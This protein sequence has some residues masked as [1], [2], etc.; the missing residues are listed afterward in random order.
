MP[1]IY[2]KIKEEMMMKGMSE[3]EAQTRAAKI[4]NAAHPNTPVGRY[5]DSKMKKKKHPYMEAAEK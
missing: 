5:H 2:E 3:D 4:Y 1:K